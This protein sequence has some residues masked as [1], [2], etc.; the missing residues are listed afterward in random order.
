LVGDAAAR[1]S[2]LTF[3]GFGATVRSLKFTADAIVDQ[4]APRHAPPKGG[5]V[6][7]APIHAGTGALARL[8]AT[9]S[10]DP[11]RKGELNDLLDVSFRVL[12]SMGNDAYA[13]LLRD[14]MSP[15]DFIRFL[16]TTAA[17][18]PRVYRDV[19]TRMGPA[20]VGRWGLQIA[21]ELR[22]APR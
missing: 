13:A 8:M 5:V 14:E 17:L 11:A 21:R 12:H 20:E 15:A 2:P 3:C 7:D 16:R 9:P 6:C 4:L 22:R 19:F 18:R 1:H 10:A